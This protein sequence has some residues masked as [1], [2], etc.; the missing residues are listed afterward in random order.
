MTMPMLIRGFG[1]WFLYTVF[2]NFFILQMSYSSK[3]RYKK[4]FTT[5]IVTV[6]KNSGQVMNS[7]VFLII[8]SYSE[9]KFPFKNKEKFS[10]FL[11][12]N[13][14]LDRFEFFIAS[15]DLKKKLTLTVFFSIKFI[16]NSF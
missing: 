1:N 6:V 13:N 16:K 7:I 5:T 15:K 2:L 14:N 4:V 8:P 10:I 9:I 11:F 12:L 3:I